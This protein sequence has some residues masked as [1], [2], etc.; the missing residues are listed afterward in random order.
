MQANSAILSI[1]VV[2]LV[3]VS[4][5]G[6]VEEKI[7]RYPVAM[8][9]SDNT[10]EVNSVV[11]FNAS[12]SYDLDNDMITYSWDFGDNLGS[13]SV[14]INA[15][16]PT[17]IHIY[18]NVGEYKVRLTVS[19][20]KSSNEL[21][22]SI[23]IVYSSI[24]KKPIAVIDGNK[25]ADVEVSVND[26]IKSDVWTNLSFDGSNSYDEDGAVV[27]YE[28]DFDASNGT[29]WASPDAI[30]RKV[31]NNF[32]SGVHKV[33]LRVTDDFGEYGRVYAWT[34]V[35]Y[36]SSY[37]GLLT[38]TTP[39]PTQTPSL[40]SIPPLPPFPSP[41]TSTSDL[42]SNQ[43]PNNFSA[44]F[45][46]YLYGESIV[47]N[48]SFRS[49]IQDQ[50]VPSGNVNNIDLYVYDGKGALAGKSETPLDINATS[51]QTEEVKITAEKINATSIGPWTAQIKC[52]SGIN[53][54]YTLKIYVKYSVPTI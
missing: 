22:K 48:L 16:V 20:G 42:S 49:S 36:S 38:N 25:Y 28:W 34:A 8:F 54:E 2:V 13:N 15:I 39:T 7:N 44:E 19:D 24:N 37:F 31:A 11:N 47:V 51:N 29:N 10:A 14:I 26:K 12:G 21:S 5:S 30:G 27:S 6:C 40:P 45:N 52:T 33:T 35:N 43:N 46:V 32:K 1:T 4:F 9:I 3:L 17:A 41:S 53:V 18:Y 50:Q 23:K